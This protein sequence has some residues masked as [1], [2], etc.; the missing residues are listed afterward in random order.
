VRGV[1]KTSRSAGDGRGVSSRRNVSSNILTIRGSKTCGTA[2]GREAAGCCGIFLFLPPSCVSPNPGGSGHV[3]SA[4]AHRAERGLPLTWPRQDYLAPPEEEEK[5]PQQSAAACGCQGPATAMCPAAAAGGQGKEHG[6]ATGAWQHTAQP[7]KD[8][9][10]NR[11]AQRPARGGGARCPRAAVQPTPVPRPPAPRLA[12][13]TLLPSRAIR[14][15]ELS[16]WC[17]PRPGLDA[18]ALRQYIP[19]A[20][21]KGATTSEHQ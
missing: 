3:K 17:A 2:P 16:C 10:Y 14:P 9:A 5:A 19:N 4:R 20:C 8:H 11:G 18:G 6:P 7:V 12:R 21:T 1:Q 13:Y 15:R